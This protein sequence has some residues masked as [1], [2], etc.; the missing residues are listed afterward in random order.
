MIKYRITSTLKTVLVA[1]AALSMLISCIN[2]K[3]Y[4][5]DPA[6]HMS[7]NKTVEFTLEKGESK[8]YTISLEKGDYYIVVDTQRS[9]S[10]SSNIIGNVQL[11]KN[12]GVMVNSS[13][14]HIN[15]IAVSTRVGDK[16][17]IAKPLPAR[18]RI[19]HEIDIPIQFWLTIIPA[20]SMKF[21][22]F[23]FGAEVK[24]AKIG[25]DSGVGGSIEPL[26]DEYYKITLPAGKWSVTYG[27]SLPKGE[28]TNVQGN[29]DLLDQY[30]FMIKKSVIFNNEI[31]NQTRGEYKLTTTKPK[32]YIFRVNNSNTT[33]TYTYDLTIDKDTD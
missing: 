9:D 5:L 13:L 14:L 3:S 6:E 26:K 2:Q 4:A 23:G 15:E 8:D 22:P 19:S 29:A 20:K 32:T 12:N 10:N 28:S 27:L 17:H 11:L 21:I 16:F 1:G 33:N 25:T 18:L 24:D 30:G 7:V 31:G